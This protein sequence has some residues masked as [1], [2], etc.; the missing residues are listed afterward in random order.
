MYHIY[1]K[2][3]GNTWHC[4]GTIQGYDHSFD[5]VDIHSAQSKMREFIA[6]RSIE[7]GCTWHEPTEYVWDIQAPK[8]DPYAIRYQRHRLDY[9]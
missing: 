2:Q 7:S 9:L 6:K 5:G 8:L 3:I 1:T 4:F